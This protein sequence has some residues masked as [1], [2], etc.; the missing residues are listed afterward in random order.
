MNFQFIPIHV[1]TEESYSIG[2]I[3]ALMT[4]IVACLEKLDRTGE[5]G[6]IDLNSLPFA[7][8]EYEQLRQT[9]GR[10]EVS[11]HIEAIGP[12]EIFETHYP[13][14]WW[15]THSNVEG[16]IVAD[17]IEI[18]YLPQIIRSQSEDVHA[19]LDRLKAQL[20]N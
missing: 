12:S 14:V 8:G 17:M 9:L 19:G 1:Q 15:A 10:G 3:Q 16:E 7:P 13:G 6:I 2:N 4:E 18:T 5:T 20:K 11:V